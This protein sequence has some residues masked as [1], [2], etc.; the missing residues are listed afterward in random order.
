MKGN[1]KTDR[2]YTLG[3]Y[4]FATFEDELEEIPAKLMLNPK[5]VNSVRFLQLLSFETTYAKYIKTKT[6]ID[7]IK[8][9]DKI[10]EVLENMKETELET[11]HNILNGTSLEETIPPEDTP[12][13]E[14]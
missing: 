10:L 14:D 13:L 2:R 9:I 12:Q 5:F 6:Y 1:I 3:D 11:L 8:D 4:R 7:S